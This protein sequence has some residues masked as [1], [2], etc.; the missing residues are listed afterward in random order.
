MEQEQMNQQESEIDLGALLYALWKHIGLIVITTLLCGAIMFVYNKS[1]VTPLYQSTASVFVLNRTSE[2]SITSS[3]ISSSTAL[4]KDFADLATSHLVVDRVIA[5]LELEQDYTYSRL[6]SNITVS[7]ADNSRMLRVMVTD[8]DPE[9]TKKLTDAVVDVLVDVVA[10]RVKMDINKIDEGTLP[11]S[12]SSPNIMKRT[13]L[14]CAFGAF[15]AIAV[16][17]ITFLM[18]DTLK[19]E[20]D[21]E[22]H[23]QLTVLASIPM[24]S[25]SEGPS[26]KKRNARRKKGGR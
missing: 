9:M 13:L 25:G 15:I 17:V 8:A 12:P 24:E 1:F 3:D 16:I 14:G 10:D 26:K 4:T 11:E 23:L 20:T 5:D 7:I 6:R 2:N 19:N 21:I 18:D 22:K